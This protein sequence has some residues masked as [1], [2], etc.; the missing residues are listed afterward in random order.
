[1]QIHCLTCV[2]LR[3]QAGILGHS[4]TEMKAFFTSGFNTL[5]ISSMVFRLAFRISAKKVDH[6]NVI[7]Y[8]YHVEDVWDISYWMPGWLPIVDQRR[9]FMNT[10]IFLALLAVSIQYLGY[11]C[12][13]FGSWKLVC[14][15][16][17]FCFL[18][19]CRRHSQSIP[20]FL[21]L[22]ATRFFGDTYLCLTK[23]V[24]IPVTIQSGLSDRRR[25]Q[26]QFLPDTFIYYTHIH[27]N[28]YSVS[29]AHALDDKCPRHFLHHYC[30]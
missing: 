24:Y 20:L 28:G 23:R 1:M 18:F 2:A 26:L 12:D 6:C 15:I 8:K 29:M 4:M 30:A 17:I 27:P 14:I 10:I 21:L 3:Y 13:D 9:I 25:N 22:L 7:F 19:L 11:L 5:K 16:C